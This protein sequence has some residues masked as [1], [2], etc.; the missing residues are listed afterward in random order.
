[1]RSRDYER[2]K[3]PS[4]IGV[5]VLVIRN[6]KILLAQRFNSHG[7]G[8]WSPPGGHLE[9]GESIEQCALRELAEETGLIAHEAT[10]VGWVNDIFEQEQK[11]YVTFFVQIENFTGE[12]MCMEPH[13]SGEWQWFHLDD[14]P[15]PLFLP[16]KSFFEYYSSIGG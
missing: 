10:H 3:A 4:R 7:H 9:F 8:T 11:H 2:N 5:G 6:N 15:E 1:M 16:T 14:L 12:P 13:K